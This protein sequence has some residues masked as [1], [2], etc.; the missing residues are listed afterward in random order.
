MRAEI[1]AVRTTDELERWVARIGA[2]PLALDLEADSFH[3]YRSKV[4][5][6]QLG[7]AE[8]V[9][10]V[11]PLGGLAM[12]PLASVL[13][14]AG[15]RKVL[16]GADYDLRILQ[17][18]FGFL[19]RGLFD[20]MIAS[21]LVGERAFGLAALVEARLG[22]KLDKR[23]QRADWSARPLSPE[24]EAYAA[25]DV[26]HL[27]PI[28]DWLEGRLR[29][30]GR[31]A[32]AEEEF[33]KLEDI[34]YTAEPVDPEGFRRVRG[35][36]E[37]SARGLA[38]LR[39]I[40]A[41]REDEAQARDVPPFKIVR[42]EILL[43]LARAWPRTL[44]ELGRIPGLPRRFVRGDAAERLLERVQRALTLPESALPS[45][46]R[47]ARVRTD[48][49]LEERVRAF[50]KRRDVLATELDLEVSVLASRGVIEGLIRAVDAGQDPA[51]APG[52]RAWQ[53][54]L[55]VP[56]LAAS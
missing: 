39:D 45:I 35:A 16:H 19:T 29:S 7:C 26:R 42:D 3:H 5:L 21:R 12:T 20:T 6:V 40:R 14:D 49:A 9:A 4:C 34:R 41:L 51:S 24:M 1:A 30:L 44:G 2:G 15:V 55:L 22:V 46:E 13:D 25:E 52:V 23:H 47:S 48:R 56:L 33:R 38:V 8:A 43:E 17:R 54:P 50:Q 37:L 18:D 31:L 27:M 10:L 53:V 28:A 11:D 36:R 32:W